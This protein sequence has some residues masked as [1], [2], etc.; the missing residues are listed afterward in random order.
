MAYLHLS[1]LRGLGS[2]LTDRAQ[3]YG[4]RPAFGTGGGTLDD[5]AAAFLR[6]MFGPTMMPAP[7]APPPIVTAPP[8]ASVVVSNT[9]PP[10]A[11]T[12]VAAPPAQAVWTPDNYTPPNQQPA[13]RVAQITYSEGNFVDVPPTVQSFGPVGGGENQAPEPKS[14]LLLIL[15][16]IGAAV[17]L[18][19]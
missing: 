12:P 7:P 5:Q 1:G 14:N 17:G 16:A 3:S 2:I 13:A 8:P 15:L 10:P 19:G 6:A 9:P 11:Q 4:W 18:G